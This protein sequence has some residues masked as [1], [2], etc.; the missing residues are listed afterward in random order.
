MSAPAHDDWEAARQK[1]NEAATRFI[2]QTQGTSPGELPGLPA[3]DKAPA[4]YLAEFYRWDAEMDRISQ[5]LAAN[6]PEASA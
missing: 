3:T 1:R 2:W 6:G 4:R 5:E